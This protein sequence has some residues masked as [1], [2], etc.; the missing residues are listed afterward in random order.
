VITIGFAPHYVETLPF[1]RDQ[2]EGSD[3]IILEEP[4]SPHLSSVLTGDFSIDDYVREIDS[5][6]PE[7][8]KKLCV[9]LQELHAQGKQIIQV[10][11]YLEKLFRIHELFEEGKLRRKYLELPNWGTFTRSSVR[12]P[13]RFSHTMMPARRLF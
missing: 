4:P 8:E 6:F 7:F 1:V 12:R 11:P 5:G 13:A 9:L 2:M 3:I 10:E